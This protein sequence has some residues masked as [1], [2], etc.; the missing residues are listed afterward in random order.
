MLK[1]PKN[2]I[3]YKKFLQK[4]YKKLKRKKNSKNKNDT[5]YRTA[6]IF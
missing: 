2:D 5:K 3:F 1:I 6:H 4:K